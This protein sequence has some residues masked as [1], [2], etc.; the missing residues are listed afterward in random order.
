MRC[1]GCGRELSGKMKY[2]KYC[3]TLLDSQN[4]SMK[5]PSIKCK[6][7][8]TY[9]EEEDAFC[10]HCGSPAKKRKASHGKKAFINIAFIS[11]FIIIFVLMTVLGSMGIPPFHFLPW[12]EVHPSKKEQSFGNVE[13]YD[14]EE[15]L[16]IN[17]DSGIFDLYGLEYKAKDSSELYQ[18]LEDYALYFGLENCYSD[19]KLEETTNIIDDKAYKYQQYYNNIP[20]YGK[21]ITVTVGEDDCIISIVNNTIDCSDVDTSVNEN[22][23]LL[24]CSAIGITE[25]EGRRVSSLYLYEREE[26]IIPVY[27]FRID[28]GDLYIIDAN[29]GDVLKHS[30]LLNTMGM[31]SKVLEGQS[32]SRNVNILNDEGVYYLRD[33]NRNIAV[34][35]SIDITAKDALPFEDIF[36]ASPMISF[37]DTGTVN[38]SAVDALYNIQKVYDFYKET[39]HHISSDGKG[40][41]EIRIYNGFKY[42]KKD[43]KIKDYT[44]NAAACGRPEKNTTEILI[45]LRSKGRNTYSDNIDVMGHEFTHSIVDY[46]LD[47]DD[48][49]KEEG[50]ALNEGLSDILGLM[51]EAYYN[52]GQCDWNIS[53]VRNYLTND[54]I[55]ESYK[56]YDRTLDCHK[57]GTII[58]ATA[59]KMWEGDKKDDTIAPLDDPVLMAELWYRTICMINKDLDYAQCRDL[60]EL[61][62]LNMARKGKVS[63]KQLNCIMWAFS[64][65]EIP[66]RLNSGIAN[67]GLVNINSFP[68]DVDLT[69]MVYNIKNKETREYTLTVYDR[70]NKTIYVADGKDNPIINLDEGTYTL[71]IT[72]KVDR[73]VYREKISVFKNEG[74][75]ALNYKKKNNTIEIHTKIGIL[76]EAKS[77]ASTN[78]S[79]ESGENF[80]EESYIRNMDSVA[81]SVIYHCFEEDVYKWVPDL[82]NKEYFWDVLFFYCNNEYETFTFPE[83]EG[84]FVV[85]D[86]VLINAAYACFKTFNGTLPT[87]DTSI[88]RVQ[89]N[90]SE[91]KQVAWGDS[92]VATELCSYVVNKDM[93]VDAV[94]ALIFWVDEDVPSRYYKV[95][96]I[97]NS[98]YNDTDLDIKYHFTVD[99]VE[100]IEDNT[101]ATTAIEER[102]QADYSNNMSLEVFNIPYG[103]YIGDIHKEM[104]F[105]LQR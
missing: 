28:T 62:A 102:S 68:S 86:K 1:N 14:K 96:Y 41:S 30:N 80:Y 3:G 55:L 82:G 8:G 20:V 66:Y 94:Y 9:M 23:F 89:Y 44:D 100:R 21:G 34:Y 70:W 46:V 97:P 22:G 79:T 72:S 67:A 63:V 38:K 95:H 58:C 98:H 53:G 47:N 99:S 105:C 31:E 6:S 81:D 76:E 29:N 74:L 101:G 50:N 73:S 2:C 61:N 69:P 45:G 11:G 75:Q 33:T 40:K 87:I 78:E 85:P 18:I 4:K 83:G 36:N 71:L 64:Q 92:G 16:W 32:T 54:N 39:L 24:G 59:R 27:I 104:E 26:D 93:S 19:L 65:L 43:N 5:G 12:L 48:F 51:I 13:V 49:S 91:S 56:Q 10:P 90:D 57:G 15:N 37:S 17:E 7:C 42:Y 35:N 84:C 77:G 25:E 52:D 60:C 103:Y 88:W